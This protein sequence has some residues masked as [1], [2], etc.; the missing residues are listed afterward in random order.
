MNDETA[1]TLITCCATLGAVMITQLFT[2]LNSKSNKTDSIYKQ[3][4]DNIFSPIHRILFFASKNKF[5]DLECIRKIIYENYNLSSDILI[6]EF[7]KCYSNAEITNEFEN[8]ILSGYNLLK[9]KLGYSKLK[10]K[11]AD[12]Q[13]TAKTIILTSSK[14]N[15][16]RNILDC[17]FYTLIPIILILITIVLTNK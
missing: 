14:K 13:N 6:K 3:Q 2:Y 15:L 16:I 4:Y 12:K 11:K 1:R 17:L 10:M 7:N 8:I 9:N 5:E